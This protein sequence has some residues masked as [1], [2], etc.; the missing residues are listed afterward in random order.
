MRVIK[1]KFEFVLPFF[2]TVLFSM[3]LCS[4]IAVHGSFTLPPPPVSVV[5]QPEEDPEFM[6][7]IEGLSSAFLLAPEIPEDPVFDSYR[8]PASR[9][10]V[11]SFFTHISGSRDIAE[12]VLANAEKYNVSP[13]LAFALCWEESRYKPSAVNRKN[14]NGSIDRGLFQLNSQTFPALTDADFFNPQVNARHGMAHLR[15]CLDS[16]G[17]EIAALA[18]YNAGTGKVSSIGTPRNTLD[19][20]S[21]ILSSRQKIDSL[22]RAEIA[23]VME[24]PYALELGIVPASSPEAP[25]VDISAGTELADTAERSRFALLSPLSGR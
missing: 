20:I 8:D 7:S 24:S 13:S 1:I 21:R 12:A 11:I 19:Y 15:W 23:H 5:V 4:F 10:W 14:M 25:L 6:F 22:F 3:N 2:L 17:S 9:G 18:I 16:G